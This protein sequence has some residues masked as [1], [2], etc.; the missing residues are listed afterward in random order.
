MSMWIFLAFG[1]YARQLAGDAIV[2]PHAEG[3]QQVGVLDGVVDPGL[4][5]HAHHAEVERM[6]R[7]Q[8]ADAEQRHGHR[9]VRALGQRRALRS[10]PR[11]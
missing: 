3:D 10:S 11:S 2:E 7:R 8:R 9:H 5:V 6:M 1:A 4:A